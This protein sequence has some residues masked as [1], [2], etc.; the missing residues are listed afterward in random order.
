MNKILIRRASL[1]AA[2]ACALIASPS[3]ALASGFQLIEQNGSGLGNAYAGQAAAAEDASA[4]FFN[5]AGLTRVQGLQVVAAL[6]LIRPSPDFSDGG[7]TPATLQPTLGGTGGDGGSLALVPN[8][9]VSFETVPGVIWTGLGLSVPFGLE[10]EWDSGWMGRFHAIKSAVQTINLNPTVAWKVAPWLSLGAGANYQWLDAELTNS[11]NYS[12]A[13]FAVGGATALGA[14]AASGC[15]GAT[16]GCEGVAN[17]SGDTWSWGW[18]VGALVEL[19]TKTRV[20]VSYRSR[21]KHYVKG[22]VSFANRPALLA[23]GLPDG[24]IQTTIELPDTLSA[25]VAQPVGD[26][27]ELLADY[28]WTGW[29][30]LKDLSIFRESGAPLTSTPLEFD[31]SWRVGLGASYRATEALKIRLGTA[32]DRTPVQDE[33]RTPRLPDEDRWWLAGGVQ[34]AFTRQAALDVG[35]AYLIIDEASSDLPNVDASP[36]AGFSAPPRGHL[37]GSYDASVWLASAQVRFSF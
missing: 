26:A 18:N 3:G 33:F 23:A 24:A 9:Y 31:D 27:L 10:T 20:G 17:V 25:A 30:T 37:V 35:A 34:W 19:P 6:N 22:D 12:A 8:G 21:I 1:A 16:G 28:T 13:A 36:P 11:V 4:I 2:I 32:Y 7:S 5:P 14:L 29:S 15:G